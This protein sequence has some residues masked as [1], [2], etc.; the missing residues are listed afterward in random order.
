MCNKGIGYNLNEMGQSTCLVFNPITVDGV[1]AHF[2]CMPSDS[3]RAR[4]KA[5]HFSW[6]GPKSSSVA[7]ST[8][9]N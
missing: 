1:A 3:L 9:V 5:I 4:P 6:L 8:G 2:N 7:K